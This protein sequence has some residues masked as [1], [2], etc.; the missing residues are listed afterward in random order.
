[1]PI[2]SNKSRDC[3][4]SLLQ[5][6][7][8]AG[9]LIASFVANRWLVSSTV[10]EVVPTVVSLIFLPAFIKVAVVLVFKWQGVMGLL[11]GV[12]YLTDY[13]RDV[14]IVVFDVLF[15]ASG[16]MLALL[17]L[18]KFGKLSDTLVD[19]SHQ[20]IIML[21]LLSGIIQAVSVGIQVQ[22]SSVMMYVFAGDVIGTVIM[23]YVL[24]LA[25]HSVQYVINSRYSK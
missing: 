12:S 4:Y 11:L 22:D 16:P 6:I 13:S 20:H 1:M 2:Y 19:L 7:V 25:I 14:G 5:I 21:G 24:S 23:L 18:Q 9:L 17:I 15:F 8:I 10:L 3:F